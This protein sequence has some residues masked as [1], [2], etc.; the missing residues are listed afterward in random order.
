MKKKKKITVCTPTNVSLQERKKKNNKDITK[1]YA[2]TRS[3][4]GLR[5]IGEAKDKNGKFEKEYNVHW[6]HEPKGGPCLLLFFNANCR[7]SIKAM[8]ARK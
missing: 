7:A 6:D 8:D 3:S 1:P 4:S 5:L 2:Q